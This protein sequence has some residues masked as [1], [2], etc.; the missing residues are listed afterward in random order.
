MVSQLK[1]SGAE[2]SRRVQNL[3]TL[4]R[5]QANRIGAGNSMYLPGSTKIDE[6]SLADMQEVRVG[7]RVPQPYLD[8]IR[9]KYTT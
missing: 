7:Q 9:S 6:Q 4:A 8:H 5:V 3:L 1:G 2:S